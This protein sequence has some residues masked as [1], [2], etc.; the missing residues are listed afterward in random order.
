MRVSQSRQGYQRHAPLDL[1]RGVAALGILLIN[2]RFMGATSLEP[3]PGGLA[4]WLDAD[5]L[6][7]GAAAITLEGAMRGLFTLLFGAGIALA[8]L[9]GASGDRVLG[10]A[11][12][13]ALL[14][15]ANAVLLLWPGDV[16]F[17]YALCVP[18]LLL[19]R[20]WSVRR[21]CAA[22]V[23]L[24][25][26]SILLQGLRTAQMRVDVA[27]GLEAEVSAD[28]GQ[29]LTAVEWRKLAAREAALMRAGAASASAQ[30]DERAARMG[31]YWQATA[32]SAAQWQRATLTPF[33]AG[34]VLE[35]LAMMLLGILLLRYWLA[36]RT[37]AGAW[38]L[39]AMGYCVG[40]PAKCWVVAATI[41]GDG[42]LYWLGGALEHFGRI[43][44]ALGHAGAIMAVCGAASVAGRVNGALACV[45][46]LALS[47]YLLASALAGLWFW[48]FRQWGQADWAALWLIALGIWAVQLCASLWWEGRYGMGPAERLLRAFSGMGLPAAGANPARGPAEAIS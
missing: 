27:G 32:W 34:G 22:V 9:H 13:L 16:L 25:A 29:P 26:A 11:F 48:G 15:A 10:R 7:W 44:M 17:L 36:H 31:N 14:G 2:I 42:S 6:I 33:L 28:L 46:R 24:L 35:T 1:L 43:G 19:M 5:W 41:H 30:A 12:G 39:A 40:L 18:L 37:A 47:N 23:M 4:N 8:T 38:R 20:A 3:L 21:L 45:G